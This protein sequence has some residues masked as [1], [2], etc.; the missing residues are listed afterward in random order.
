M[1]A[2][3]ALHVVAATIWVGGMI[4]M[5]FVVRPVAVDLFT[6]AE[7]IPFL[8]RAMGR[9]FIIVWAAVITLLITGFWMVMH[10]YGGFAGAHWSIHAMTGIGML[11]VLKFF[12]LYFLPYRRLLKFSGQ[13]QWSE[14]A[15][16]LNSVRR[17]VMVNGILGLLVIVLATTGRFM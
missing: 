3:L 15:G 12:Y 7:R 11:M 4:T 1:I 9:F 16:Q 10:L 8:T 14:A 5:V 13:E 17:V 2:A 6:P